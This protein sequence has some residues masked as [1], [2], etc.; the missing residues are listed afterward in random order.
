MSPRILGTAVVLGVAAL[1]A[2][3]FAFRND[4]PPVPATVPVAEGM[5]PRVVEI[6]ASD[7]AFDAPDSLAAGPVTFK[8]HNHGPDLHH[9][10]IVNLPGTKTLADLLAGTRGEVLPAW[11]HS[12]GGPG[13]QV[14]GGKGE[15]SLVLT[16]GRW[17]IVCIVPAPD[18]VPH[19]NK[20]MMHEFVVTAPAVQNV[21]Q[22]RPDMSITLN[23]YSFTLS[24]EL[25]AGR[26]LIEVRNEAQQHHEVIFVKL[27]PGKHIQ[28]LFDWFADRQGPP[29]GAMVGGTAPFH[30]GV[31]N[32]VAIDLEPGTYGLVCFAGDKSDGRPHVMYGMSREIEVR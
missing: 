23:D 19:L 20:G 7:Y 8:F 18:G 14:P 1:G 25:T 29:P 10:Y 21:A 3:A 22:G 12:I 16:E 6:T 15:T 11:A 27:Q 13:A 2:T 30:P 9:V 24:K 32:T 17:A 26:H 5:V 4:S 28:D 31:I